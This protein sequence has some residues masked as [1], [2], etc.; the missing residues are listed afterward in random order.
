MKNLIAPM[1]AIACTAATAA[2]PL[3]VG[4]VDVCSPE[5]KPIPAGYLEAFRDQGA[6]PRILAW[7]NDLAAIDQAVKGIDLLMLCGGEDVDPARYHTPPSPKLGTVN[8]K[9]DEFEWRLLD[10][11]MRRHKPVFGICRGE[12]LINV[13][14]GGTLWQD[15]PSEFPVHEVLHRRGDANNVPVH[16]FRPEAGGFMAELYGI[17]Q[18]Y[19]NSTHHQAVKDVAPG[20]VVCG[21]ST[22]GVIEAIG[23]D[24]LHVHGVQFHPERLFDRYD[25]WRRLFKYVVDDAR[26]V[27]GN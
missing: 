3:V 4:V 23:N 18:M 24:A 26:T 25:P 20:F 9:R 11:A 19:V 12:Q 15:L 5:G 21:R 27:K 16:G 22:D 7:T 14:F 6:E 13:Y 2:T 10:A 17:D 8:A 1:L